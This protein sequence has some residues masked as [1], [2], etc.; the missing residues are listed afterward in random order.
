M[1]ACPPT[2]QL[3]APYPASEL[4]AC[5]SG[6]KYG[7]SR[8]G[9]LCGRRAGAKPVRGLF[10]VWGGRTP[11][12]RVAHPC[13]V[14]ESQQPLKHASY[15]GLPVQAGQ[16]QRPGS[17]ACQRP[18]PHRRSRTPSRPRTRSLHA[19][20]HALSA[21]PSGAPPRGLP[22]SG[23]EMKRGSTPPAT[24]HARA[25]PGDALCGR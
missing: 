16:V 13:P 7:T 15:H 4:L 1:W 18:I 22:I 8:P 11:S 17:K 5:L 19:S 6:H 2:R 20:A 24:S 3:G 9:H 10:G 23:Y 25:A 12:H 21:P 14:L